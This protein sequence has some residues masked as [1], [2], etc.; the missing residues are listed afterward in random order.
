MRWRNLMPLVWI[1][2]WIQSQAA[3]DRAVQGNE[4][5]IRGLCLKLMVLAIGQRRRQPTIGAPMEVREHPG[6]ITEDSVGRHIPPEEE[7]PTE[8]PTIASLLYCGALAHA[9]GP[10]NN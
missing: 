5:S 7:P 2:A 1:R 9:H 8:P 4:F 10:S 3:W 6:E